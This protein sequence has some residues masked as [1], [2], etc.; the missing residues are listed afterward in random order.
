MSKLP[1]L[2]GQFVWCMFPFSETPDVPG[3]TRHVAYIVD[4]VQRGNHVYVAAALYTTTSPKSS[5]LPIG[6]IAMRDTSAKSVNQSDFFID[7]RRI[8]YMPIDT[9]FFPDL[10]RPGKGIQ[11]EATKGLQHKIETTLAQMLKRPE[12]IELLGPERPGRPPKRPDPKQR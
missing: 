7:A 6:V 10:T 12:L 9:A 8:A 5:P 1:Y 3:P 2:P 4:I 11:G